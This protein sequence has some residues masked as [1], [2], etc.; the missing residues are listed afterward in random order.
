MPYCDWSV[1]ALITD[2]A[3]NSNTIDD[4]N[5]QAESMIQAKHSKSAEV[6]KRQAEIN[7]RYTYCIVYYCVNPNLQSS[8]NSA[9]D[10]KPIICLFY[11][12][13]VDTWVS[14]SLASASN[15][16]WSLKLAS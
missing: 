1:Q 6:K 7:D 4:I 8:F 15:Q 2:L 3:A 13:I 12:F 10:V 14:V 11:I 9:T 5:K 16:C